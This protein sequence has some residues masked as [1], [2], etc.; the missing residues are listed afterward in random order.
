[1]ILVVN[2]CKEKMHELEFVRPIEDLIKKAGLQSF[3]KHYS[4]LYEDDI[5]EA[6]KIIICGTAVKDFDYLENV[7]NFMWIKECKKPVLGICAG[8]QILGKIFGCEMHD[9][10]VIGQQEMT[11]VMPNELI[12][13]EQF[14]SYFISTKAIKLNNDFEVLARGKEL[15]ALVKHKSKRVYGCWFHP[16]VMNSQIIINFC[17]L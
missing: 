10:E 8:M 13:E 17:K 12:E 1:M 3:T 14:F 4:Q 7:Q 9:K 5:N 15:D 16:E 11:L 6:E 2:L